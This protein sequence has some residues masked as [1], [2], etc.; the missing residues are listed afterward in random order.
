MSEREIRQKGGQW[1]K[2][3]VAH[4]CSIVS[5]GNCTGMKDGVLFIYICF[6]FERQPRSKIK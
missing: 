1:C 3:D 5:S 6:L 2:T 4:V